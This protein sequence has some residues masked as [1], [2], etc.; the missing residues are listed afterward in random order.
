MIS[1][2]SNPKVKQVAQWQTNSGKRREEGVFLAEGFK[3]C[4]EAPERDVRE[5]YITQEALEKAGTQPALREKLERI[6]Y[7][8]VSSEVFRKMSDTRTPQ[9]ILC[10]VKR[11]ETDLERL[12][13][14]ENPL[15]IVLEDLQDPGNLGTIVRTGEGAGVTG[16]VMSTRTV[17]IYNPKTIRATMGSIYRVP[18]VCAENLCGA[19]ERMREKGIR[20]Y[21]AH[22]AG[23]NYYDNLN[24]RQGTAFLIG[25][26]G[27]GLSRELTERADSL[28]KIPMEGSVES[29]NAAVSAALMMYEARRQRKL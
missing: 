25:N 15:L 27:N 2:H 11:Q 19:V 20:V 4:E 12:L 9:G 29:L 6:G 8:T 22:L 26:E 14:A 18:F 16:I 23:E 21:A 7:E 1:S 10:V 3:M 28:L 24:F 17:D 13:A 5:I